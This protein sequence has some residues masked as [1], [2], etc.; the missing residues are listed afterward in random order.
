MCIEVNGP[1]PAEPALRAALEAIVASERSFFPDASVV[2]LPDVSDGTESVGASATRIAVWPTKAVETLALADHAAIGSI[3]CRPD[4]ASWG[5]TISLPLL[6]AGAERILEAARQPSVGG[7]LIPADAEATISVELDAAQSRVRT[8]LEF[9][10]PA[11]PFRLGGTCW[12]D[13]VLQ[14]DPE[15]GRPSA[16][17]TTGMDVAPFVESGC[18][19]F[20]QFM[21]GRG[22]GVRALDLVPGVTTAVS[23]SPFLVTA[24]ISVAEDRIV[25]SGGI[26]GSEH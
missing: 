21:A 20:E 7:A 10:V 3:R 6:Q 16:Q 25:L 23:T 1:E 19:K 26:P 17:L 22:A 2:T 18:A 4:D 11:G 14:L 24:S 5:A 15:S 13:E 9:S 12:I 8:K